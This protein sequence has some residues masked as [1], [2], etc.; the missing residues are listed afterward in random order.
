MPAPSRPLLLRIAEKIRAQSLTSFQRW[1]I[2]ASLPATPAMQLA[3]DVNLDPGVCWIWTGAFSKKRSRTRRPNIR[4]GAA[5]LGT[6]NPVRVLLSLKDGVPLDD[7]ADLH[8]AH[9]ECL[10]LSCINPYHFRWATDAENR[11]DRRQATI[12][13]LGRLI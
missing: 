11:D 13:G 4:V 12:A 3:L 10:N 6:I 8:A 9:T 2:F 7:R 5:F 1:A